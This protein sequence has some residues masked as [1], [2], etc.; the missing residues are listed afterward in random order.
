M[1]WPL[2]WVVLA[3]GPLGMALAWWRIRR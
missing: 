3:L 2:P 1:R